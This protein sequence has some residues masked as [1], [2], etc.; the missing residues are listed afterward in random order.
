ME[1]RI[2]ELEMRVAFQDDAIEKLTRA[3]DEQQRAFYKLEKELAE[4]RERLEAK[5]EDNVIAQE[6]EAPPPHY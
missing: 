1:D 5:T 2:Q 4:V 6:D 3:L